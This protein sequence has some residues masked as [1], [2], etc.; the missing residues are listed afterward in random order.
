MIFETLESRNALESYVL[1]MRNRLSDELSAFIK[2][3]EREA[4]NNTLSATEDWLYNEGYEAQKSEYKKRLAEL[5]AIGDPVITRK[6]E[7]E[8]REAFVGALKSSIGHYSNWSTNV[9]NS[10]DSQE[11]YAH[12]SPEERKKILEEAT[13]VDEWLSTIL[14]QQSKLSKAENPVVTNEQLRLKR[15]ALENFCNTI[16]K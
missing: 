4:F 11:K 7:E 10:K 15:V 1:E 6:T 13:K 3:K 12:I 9:N 5:K 2:D 16:I 8:N 14:T